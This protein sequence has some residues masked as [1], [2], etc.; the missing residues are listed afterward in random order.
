MLN[1]NQNRKPRHLPRRNNP[2]RKVFISERTTTPQE[3]TSWGSVASWYDEYLQAENTY[4]AKVI[5]PNLLRVLKFEDIKNGAH[6][7][8]L[9]CGQGYFLHQVA[10]ALK[11]KKVSLEGVDVSQE[12]LDIA[13]KDIV[14]G[15]KLTR[16]DAA[17]LSH[18]TDNSTD[19]IYSVLALQNMSDLDAVTKEIKRVLTPK[20]RLIAVLNHPTFR[21][22][23]QS[24][25]HYSADR[26]A[27]GRVIYTY[28]SDK[29]FAIDM[30]P[31]LRAAGIKKEETFS[32]HHP[33]QFYSKVLAKHGFCIAKIEEWLSHKESEEGPKKRAEDESRKEIPMFM[34]LEIRPF[35]D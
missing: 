13:K 34:M 8:E 16:A 15:I 33:L 1:Q 19:L 32:F 11:N 17:K 12:L 6:V 3:N 18:L 23:K 21:I 9:G 7:L 22:P 25:W 30:H 4:Q 20:G 10:E 29:K 27:Q 14:D 28:M 2:V 35:I 26:N 5:S 31:G 24:D